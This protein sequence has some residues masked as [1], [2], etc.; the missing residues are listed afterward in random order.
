[1]SYFP[2]S[3]EEKRRTMFYTLLYLAIVL[4]LVFLLLLTGIRPTRTIGWVLVILVLPVGG[5]LLYLMFGVNRRRY[6]FYKRKRTREMEAY[7]ER[8]SR[9]YR[10]FER[11]TTDYPPEVKQNQRLS[12]LIIQ[13]SSFLPQTGNKVEL[14]K[15]GPATFAAIF[16]ALEQARQFIHIQFYIFEEG[17][18][19]GRFAEIF[20]RKAK[21]GVEI[22]MIYDGVGSRKLSRK[23]RRRLEAAGVKAY[24]F[25][26][27]RFGWLTTTLNYRN[28]RK[29]IVVDGGQGF[30]GGINVAD[31]YIRGDELGIWH[32]MHLHLQGP[33]VNNLQAIFAV[34]WH[35]V[36]GR[37]ELL[38]QPYTFQKEPRGQ[39]T[40][41]LVSGG[42]DSDFPALRQ[43]YFSLINQ[44]Q[45]YVYITNPYIIPGEPLLE[46]LQ[47]AAL[48]GVDVRVLTPARSDNPVVKWSIRS[49]FQPLL[50]AGV[51][52]YLYPHGFLHSKTIVADDSV[53]SVGTANL[54]IRSFEQ[55]FEVN[56][57]IY[58]SGIARQ[59]KKI[60]HKECWISTQLDPAAYA[61]RPWMDRLKE[62]GG[63]VFS[64]IL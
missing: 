25:M 22:R 15:D 60:F 20:E 18:L 8:V 48:G 4:V 13:N 56:A 35:F 41:Q 36:S 44:A 38:S 9:F 43:H 5:I 31:K 3:F 63:K 1:M 49:Y 45:E 50:E 28:H 42:P 53:A 12:K 14:L 27:L 16:E 21:E 10:E 62:G 30:T 17:E 26:P 6:K 11:E 32:D 52:I 57:V 24:P 47:S 59:L 37:E 7:Y 2:E 39:S 34:D 55:N 29:I 64:P 51:K 19:A 61:E 33:V 58:D 46:A 40:V 23:Y 54:D